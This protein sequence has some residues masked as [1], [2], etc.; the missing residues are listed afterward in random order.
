MLFIKHITLVILVH[1]PITISAY[2]GTIESNSPGTRWGHVLVYDQFR[3]QLVLFG[4]SRERGIYLNDTWIWDGQNWTEMQV[5]GPT[6]R[7]FCAATFHKE[8]NSIIL[9]GGRGN[10][11]TTFSDTWEWNGKQ[12]TQLEAEGKY[13]ADHHQMV[14]VDYEKQIV[15]FGG[16]NGK[17]VMGDT[18]VWNGDWQKSNELSPPKR[19][20][21]GMVYN[22]KTQEINLFGGLWVNGQYADLWERTN[23]TWQ[24]I[25]NP[26]D[27]SSLD[28]HAMIYDEK[29]QK[30][31]GFGGKDYRRQMQN[32]TFNINNGLIETLTTEGPVNRHSFGFTYNSKN[33]LGFLYGGKIYKEDNQLALG[34]FWKWDGTKW[35]KIE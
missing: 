14:Y 26:Y 28:H 17:D 34:D 23:G 5:K 22:I 35:N 27:N 18:W 13:K 30:V 9:H 10:N 31:I 24:A 29:L 21:F 6:A 7:G 20:S 32:K 25:G 16:W 33:Q 12:W 11:R 2:Q 19:A 1:I 3:D 8:R 4:G 15:A